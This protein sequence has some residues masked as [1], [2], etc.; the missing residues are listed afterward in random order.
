MRW[1]SLFAMAEIEEQIKL[2]EECWTAIR[3]GQLDDGERSERELPRRL[4]A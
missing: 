2:L 4:A 1:G 3:P